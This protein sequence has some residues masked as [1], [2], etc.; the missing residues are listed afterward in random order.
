MSLD[1]D[2]AGSDDLGSTSAPGSSDASLPSLLFRRLMSLLLHLWSMA[3]PYV[4]PTVVALTVL[5][6]VLCL[7]I[8][9]SAFIF[10]LHQRHPGRIWR[11]IRATVL[12]DHDLLEAGRDIIATL[13][14][15]QV[16]IN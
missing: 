8:Y 16:K 2:L 14:D 1:V 12:E 11:K 7:F 13:W 15:V 6:V 5:P 3:S 4:T 10:Y 9:L